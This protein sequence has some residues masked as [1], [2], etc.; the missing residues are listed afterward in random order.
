MFLSFPRQRNLDPCWS[1]WP[2]AWCLWC[3]E[4]LIPPPL[5]LS[6]IIRSLASRIHF[7]GR[8][9][10]FGL[11]ERKS[12]YRKGLL[13]WTTLQSAYWSGLGYPCAITQFWG[14]SN[15]ATFLT[16]SERDSSRTVSYPFALRCSRSHIPSRTPRN[17]ETPWF[18]SPL[19]CPANLDDFWMGCASMTVRSRCLPIAMA[20][21]QATMLL[22]TLPLFHWKLRYLF[23][24]VLGHTPSP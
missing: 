17:A 3:T 6:V 4:S 1:S 16:S 22:L 24:A 8:M 20:A 10:S 18:G 11:C 2:Q 14:V 5:I 7:A 15:R 21:A 12:W 19:R 23:P 9:N 13:M